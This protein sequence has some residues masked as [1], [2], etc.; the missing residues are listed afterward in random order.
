MKNQTLD[1]RILQRAYISVEPGGISVSNDPKKCHPDISEPST[2]VAL[3]APTMILIARAVVTHQTKQNRCMSRLGQRGCTVS[4]PRAKTGRAQVRHGRAG[5]LHAHAP[6]APPV[7]EP[8]ILRDGTVHERTV[9]QDHPETE[10]RSYGMIKRY[11]LALA[12]LVT[13]GAGAVT[14]AK[15]VEFD[16][17]PGGVYVGPHRYRDYDRDRYDRDCR[18]VIEHRTNRF[19]EDVTVRRR[20]C[21]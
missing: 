18:V 14:S 8:L 5:A 19:G 9:L 1:T 7:A 12:A 20:I 21:D 15:A 10:R 2:Y 13:L 6:F 16:V 3:G 11:V 4:A 17:G